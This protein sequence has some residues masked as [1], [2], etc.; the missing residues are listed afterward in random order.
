MSGHG[1]EFAGGIIIP[2]VDGDQQSTAKSFHGRPPVRTRQTEAPQLAQQ[3]G[4]RVEPNPVKRSDPSKP[5]PL[6]TQNVLTLARARVRE[7]KG[8]LKRMRALERELAELQ[9]L[10]KA[11]KE[12][13]A[14]KLT[15]IR[16][17]G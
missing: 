14:A 3:P 17:T 12:K 7:I 6:S 10:I 11:A 8:E 15:S 16:R 1:F 5:K 4:H 9:R 13:P 2:I